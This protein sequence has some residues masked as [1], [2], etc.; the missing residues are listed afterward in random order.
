LKLSETEPGWTV[1]INEQNISL[2]GKRRAGKEREDRQTDRQRNK[3]V[4]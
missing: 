1:D 2:G 3:T 4:E